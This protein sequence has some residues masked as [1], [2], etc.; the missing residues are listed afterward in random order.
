MGV[1][2][3]KINK[4]TCTF[5][6]DDINFSY[7]ET[8]EFVSKANA[9]RGSIMILGPMLGRFKKGAA[10]SPGGDKIGRR[11]LDTHFIGLQKLGA[12]FSYSAQNSLYRVSADHLTGSYMLIHLGFYLRYALFV[13]I[14]GILYFL[15][16]L[17]RFLTKVIVR[18]LFYGRIYRLYFR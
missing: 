16:E 6:A 13:F 11:R 18:K 2:V 12:A 8:P 4:D 5:Q 1:K 15:F 9:L 7:L 3:E 17:K 10:P 14:G